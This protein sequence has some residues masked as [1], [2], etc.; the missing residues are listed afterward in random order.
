MIDPD[1][2]Y[3]SEPDPSTRNHDDSPVSTGGPTS[4]VLA[5][6]TPFRCDRLQLDLHVNKLVRNRELLFQGCSQSFYAE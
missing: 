2:D 1:C 5:K 6:A 3:D 4:L